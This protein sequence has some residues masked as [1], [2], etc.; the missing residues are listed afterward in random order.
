MA[1]EV[2]VAKGLIG[3]TLTPTDIEN[4][5]LKPIDG[6]VVKNYPWCISLNGDK[7][8]VPFIKFIEY[9]QTT[10]GLYQSISYWAAGGADVVKSAL[11]GELTLQSNPYKDLYYAQPTGQE[12]IFPYYNPYHHNISNSW[13]ENK[14]VP[15]QS[16]A[17]D[18]VGTVAKSMFPAGGIET[19]KAWEGTQ[20]ASYTFGFYLLNT[21]QAGWE[22]N[23]KL[24]E[25]LIRANLQYKINVVAAFPP[26]IYEVTIPYMRHSPAATIENLTINNT[27]QINKLKWGN[28]PDAYQVTISVKELITE[29]RQIFEGVSNNAKKVT[30][31]VGNENLV[32]T[33]IATGVINTGIKMAG[34]I[35]KGFTGVNSNTELAENQL[36]GK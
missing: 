33:E 17:I 12:F 23:K 31:I 21:T 30:S 5:G 19:Q 1:N 29:S 9:Q 10:S 35:E 13:G 16:E 26:V 14:G 22:N 34:A 20:S 3:G 18:I 24:V 28:V 2:P 7:S 15:G 32:G 4:L 27:G 11:K 8:D 36:P 25:R 6:N